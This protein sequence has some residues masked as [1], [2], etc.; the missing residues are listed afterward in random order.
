MASYAMSREAKVDLGSRL[1]LFV[2]DALIEKARGVS[3]KLHTP[4]PQEK[5]ISFNK[6]WEGQES[7]Y[8]SVLQDGDVYRLYYRS[9]PAVDGVERTA[10]IESR[11]GRKWT[12]PKLGL[13]EFRGSTDNNLVWDGYGNHCFAPFIDLNPQAKKSERYKAIAGCPPA[14]FVSPD[15]LH[16]KQVSKPGVIRQGAFDSLNLAFW[17]TVQ[18]QYVA[19]V[20]V[21]HDGSQAVHNDFIG[22]R[23]IGRAISPDFKTWSDTTEID[24]GNSPRE[25]LYTNAVTPY[26]RAPHLYLGF[27]KRFMED[28]KRIA[29]YR[30]PGISEAVFMSS[31]D[32][33]HFDRRFMEAMIRPGRDRDNWTDRSMMVAWGMLQTAPDELSLYYSEHYRHPGSRLRRGTLRLDGFVSVNAPFAGGQLLTKPFTF[34]GSELVLNYATAA[35]G[36]L[37]V[38]IQDEQGKALPGFALKDCPVI[39]GDEIEGVIEWQRGSAV[40]ALVGRPI[41]LRFVL[42]D[43]DLYSLRFR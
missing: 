12:R 5:I 2:D 19:Y 10:M 13:C 34:E 16:W 38:E 41:R 27:P 21:W 11:D 32:G 30:E 15:G 3:L 33:L 8:A 40:S 23:S 26:Y 9:G 17:D 6:P 31:R 20:R 37:Q 42:K 25:H 28:R 1:E 7:A 35:A 4:Q 24:Y 29:E 18:E 39:Y 22:A 14:A 36:S 43:A